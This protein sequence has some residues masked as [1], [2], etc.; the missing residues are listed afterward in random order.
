MKMGR[1]EKG[2]IKGKKNKKGKMEKGK[3]QE[4]KEEK[5]SQRTGKEV[6]RD[7]GRYKKGSD[8]KE[9]GRGK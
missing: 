2:E 4:I 7:K 9:K 6:E 1:E 3:R 8:V 5:K